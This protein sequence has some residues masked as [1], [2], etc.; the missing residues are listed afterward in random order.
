MSCNTVK[1]RP[2]PCWEPVHGEKVVGAALLALDCGRASLSPGE[3]R[4]QQRQLGSPMAQSWRDHTPRFHL[5]TSL[6]NHL[7]STNIC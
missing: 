7:P 4:L 2:V 1:L 5:Q 6:L 3:Q